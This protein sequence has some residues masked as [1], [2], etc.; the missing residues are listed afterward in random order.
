MYRRGS[1]ESYD[2]TDRSG[3]EGMTSRAGSGGELEGQGVQRERG[4]DVDIDEERKLVR[5]SRT[6]P[7]FFQPC[8]FSFALQRGKS[9]QESL[10]RRIRRAEAPSHG[11]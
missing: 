9:A 3:G 8:S 7:P 6:Y 5:V 4:S 11:I 1:G 10:R 2:I